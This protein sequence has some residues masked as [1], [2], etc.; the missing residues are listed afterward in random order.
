VAV[1]EPQNLS[2]LQPRWSGPYQVTEVV[3]DWVFVLKDLVSNAEKAVRASLIQLYSDKDLNVTIWLQEQIQ[4]DE[5]KFTVESFKEFR[6]EGGK[7]QVLT[8]R[9]SVRSNGYHVP[10]R[11]QAS[12][13]LPALLTP[14]S[15]TQTKESVSM[16]VTA[17]ECITSIS[18]QS[19]VVLEFEWVFISKME[20][21][22]IVAQPMC[23]EALITFK[24]SISNH[25][26]FFYS[27]QSDQRGETDAQWC[28]PDWKKELFLVIWTLSSFVSTLSG[29]IGHVGAQV[30]FQYQL[31]DWD[32]TKR[33]R[34]C[35][36]D[37]LESCRMAPKSNV[38]L[39]ERLRTRP[40]TDHKACF[41]DL[42]S[43][44]YEVFSWRRPSLSLQALQESLFLHKGWDLYFPSL[45]SL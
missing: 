8:R 31:H 36:S 22:S 15:R 41:L 20:S 24:K 11:S 12:T 43:S 30:S 28:C 38:L 7:Y 10:R 44:F 29:P 25:L 3:S 2:K 26:S 23:S 6:K 14:S 19:Q 39:P 40:N 21:H 42:R 32:K 33:W 16:G 18:L 1:A 4:Y 35:E 13:S 27:H 45:S 5:W 9:S 37:I 17:T 34:T